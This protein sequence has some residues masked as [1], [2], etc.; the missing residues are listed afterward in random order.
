MKKVTDPAKINQVT[1]DDRSQVYRQA[2]AGIAMD[3]AG[4][5]SVAKRVNKSR[6]CVVYNPSGTT[7]FVRFGDNTVTP[8]IDPAEAIPILPNEKTFLNSGSHEYIVASSA[9]LY[10]YL[11]EES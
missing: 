7:E 5:F 8:S 4:T 10:L 11:T 3:P 1:Y 6:T 2:D 9:L